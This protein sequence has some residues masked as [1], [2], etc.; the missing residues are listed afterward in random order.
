MGLLS[1]DIWSFL[2]IVGVG[3]GIIMCL[4]VLRRASPLFLKILLVL[5]LIL[6]ANLAEYLLLNSRYY[7]YV[8]HL[9]RVTHPFLFL[10][11]PLFYLFIKA[12]LDKEFRFSLW[13]TVH[14]IPFLAAVVYSYPW[15]T[16]PADFKLFV[17]ERSLQAKP[18]GFGIK[19]FLYP[20]I[21]ILQTLSYVGSAFLLLRKF[22]KTNT[23]I[24]SISLSRLKF[25]LQFNR[26]FMIYWSLQMMGLFGIMIAQ[27]YVLYIDYGL[28]LLNSLFIQFLSFSLLLRPDIISEAP[29]VK[30][31]QGSSL[32]DDAQRELLQKIT[33]AIKED[34]MY[35][36]GELTLQKFSDTLQV[37]KNYV[38]QV[39]NQEFGCGFNDYINSFRVEKAQELLLDPSYDN[40][41][42]LGIAFET[43]FNNKT[44]FTRVFKKKTGASPSD[45]RQQLI[46]AREKVGNN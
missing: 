14:L 38:S 23:S 3:Q 34:E 37:N 16:A 1:F 46:S 13:S 42:L 8:I 11:G 32:G 28:A 40:M 44:S 20:F 27:Y 9:M 33:T 30:K 31:Y 39:I 5:L 18:V 6:T 25:L 45:Y 26:A 43:G 29:L 35:L 12:Q 21:H 17:F 36:D 41:K 24:T 7:V 4:V 19:G 10:I 15:L 22:R 2:L